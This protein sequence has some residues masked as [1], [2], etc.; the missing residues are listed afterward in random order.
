VLAEST[1]TTMLERRIVPPWGRSAAPT[2]CPS[3]SR[4]S[5]RAPGGT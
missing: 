1:L 5:A 4:W 3:G 2:G